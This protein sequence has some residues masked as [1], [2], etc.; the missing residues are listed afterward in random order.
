ML[1]IKKSSS[2]P[3]PPSVSCRSIATVSQGPLSKRPAVTA[4]GAASVVE[5]HTS[6]LAALSPS[7]P[8]GRSL[9][10][11]TYGV[12][13]K[14]PRTTCGPHPIVSEGSI[15]EQPF[16]RRTSA[17]SPHGKSRNKA[18]HK[19]RLCV[20][21]PT[22][23]AGSNKRQNGNPSASSLHAQ[24]RQARPTQHRPA[25]HRRATPRPPPRHHLQPHP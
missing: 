15:P 20:C 25:R 5:M 14:M 16:P 4:T 6:L 23:A 24:T 21:M 13:D 12:E 18:V 8:P 3:T 10:F 7:Y 2:H 22:L 1:K 11:R 9:V 19:P 17:T